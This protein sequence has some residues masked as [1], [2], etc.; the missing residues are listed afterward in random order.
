MWIE[1]IYNIKESDSCKKWP[2]KNFREK[3]IS[4]KKISVKKNS[5]K[6]MFDKENVWQTKMCLQQ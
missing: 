1:Y 5:A 2:K 6:K 4:A 3:N